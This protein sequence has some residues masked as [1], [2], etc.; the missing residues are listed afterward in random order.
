[1][2]LPEGWTYVIGRFFQN[3]TKTSLA[4]KALLYIGVRA[5]IHPKSSIPIGPQV[6]ISPKGFT[7]GVK[8]DIDF[9]FSI[10]PKLVI[11]AEHYGLVLASRQKKGYHQIWEDNLQPLGPMFQHLLQS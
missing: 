5:N 1:V 8:A 11:N 6:E 3:Y 7:L 9:F 4:H 2:V 10:C